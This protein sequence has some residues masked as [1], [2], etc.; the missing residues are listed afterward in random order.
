MSQYS[1][2]MKFKNK[3]ES[4]K[5]PI[6]TSDDHSEELILKYKNPNLCINRIRMITAS[7]YTCTYEPVV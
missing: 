7:W 1:G 3:P 6:Q 4:E 2:T 5:V